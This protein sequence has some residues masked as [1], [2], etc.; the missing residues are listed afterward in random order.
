MTYAF[1]HCIFTLPL[2]FFLV[3]LTYKRNLKI[4]KR[5]LFGIGLLVFLAM[6]Y[7]TPWDSYLIKENIWGYPEKRVLGTF[8]YIPY[9]EYFFF[10]IQTIIGCLFTCHIL[11]TISPL[12]N[13]TKGKKV[14]FFSVCLLLVFSFAFAWPYVFKINSLRYL[15]LILAWATPIIALQWVLGFSTLWKHRREYVISLTGL[16]LFFGFAD[17]VAVKNGIWFFSKDQ[18]THINLFTHLPIEEALF[19]LC[20]NIMVVQGFILF[21]EMPFT[22]GEIFGFGK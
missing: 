15:S 19:F 13:S 16:F 4:D 11:N 2:F 12:P 18:V 21:K 7:T 8:L 9:E 14:T 6:T 20:T 17:W 3:F 22:K 1:F 10:F 5:S